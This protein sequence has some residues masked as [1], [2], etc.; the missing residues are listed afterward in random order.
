MMDEQGL[1]DIYGHV[2]KPFWQST[3]FIAACIILLGLAVA[4]LIFLYVK[5]YR[6]KPEL[7]AQQRALNALNNLAKKTIKTRKD[8]HEAYF[9]LTEILKNYFAQLYGKSF[10]GVTDQEMIHALENTPVSKESINALAQL[11]QAGLGVK[12]AQEN[13]LHNQ[14]MEH[15]VTSIHSINQN[16]TKDLA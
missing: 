11:I 10:E 4:F 5:K 1:Y 12:Y 9:A 3:I 16:K 7:S 15:V 13:A 14:V 8:A 6:K 2:H